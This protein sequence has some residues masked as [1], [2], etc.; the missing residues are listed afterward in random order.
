MYK[1]YVLEDAPEN[2][3]AKNGTPTTGGIFLVIA[4][5]IASIIALLMAQKTTTQAFIVLITLLF[6]TF[7]GFKDDIRK[8]KGKHNQGLTA[9][10]KLFFQFAIAFLPVFWYITGLSKD[11]QAQ[12]LK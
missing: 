10:G 2:H 3:K 1:Q 12:K 6:Y 4:S 7:A 8:I 9:K 5:I 11:F